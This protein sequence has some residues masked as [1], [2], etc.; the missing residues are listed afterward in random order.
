VLDGIAQ[1][2]GAIL[3]VYGM[4]MPKPLL[5]R[6]DLAFTVTPMK[7]GRDGNGFGFVGRF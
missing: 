2:T 3:F 7:I 5:V 4:S 1:A 6:N